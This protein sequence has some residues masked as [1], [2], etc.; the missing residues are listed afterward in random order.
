MSKQTNLKYKSHTYELILPKSTT[1][2]A[3][4]VNKLQTETD[5]PDTP[6]IQVIMPKESGFFRGV[7]YKEQNTLL[8]FANNKWQKLKSIK[9]DKGAEETFGAVEINTI[10]RLSR[11]DRH[12]KE[13]V[14]G[15]A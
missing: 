8:G 11:A 1:V 4:T 13:A 5:D 9:F 14:L 6:M 15:M 12:I 7:K 10:G 3:V 2:K